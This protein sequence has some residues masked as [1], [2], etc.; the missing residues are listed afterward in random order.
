MLVELRINNCLIFNEPVA[1]S[2]KAD[3]RNK[4][5]SANVHH[6][7]Q[8]HIVKAAGIFGQNNA[9]KTSLIKCL[10]GIKAIFLNKKSPLIPNL[11]TDNS[12]YALGVTFLSNERQYTYD[13]KYDA[14]MR[15]FIFEHFREIT[16]D[17]HGNAKEI[18]WLKKDSIKSEY[19]CIDAAATQTMRDISNDNIVCYLINTEKFP[20]LAEMKQHL[21]KFANKILILDMNNIPIEHTIHLLKNQNNLHEKI[22]NFV[23]NA[24]LYLDD[25]I[26]LDANKIHM[27]STQEGGQPAE[28]VLALK[29]KLIDKIRLTSVY[30]KLPV[31]TLFFDSTG[32]KKITALASYIIEAL[33]NGNILVI[34]ELDSSLHFRL[35]RSIIA[36]F[37][38]EL[39][40]TAQLLFSAHDINLIDCKHLFRKDQIWFVHKDMT[41]VYLYSLASYTAKD[42]FRNDSDILEKYKQ[43]LMGAVPE[44]DLISSLLEIKRPSAKKSGAK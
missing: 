22:V 39:N 8:Y 25:L 38:N 30:R 9:G 35:T 33:Q 20:H 44:P 42:G 28:D 24:D 17:E 23:K 37:N 21:Q 36:L 11:F 15:E 43:G 32:T 31:P 40:D 34:D 4:K 7:K 41:Q 19:D 27:E 16:V 6:I 26:F 3:M 18:T 13:F 5:F 2:L 1:M 12:I 10:R 29:E 14:H